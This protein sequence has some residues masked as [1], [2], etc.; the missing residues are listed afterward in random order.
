MYALSRFAGVREALS[1][2][3][4]FS[5]AQGV[6]MNEDANSKIKGN[7]LG[8]DPPLHTQLRH[9]LARPLMPSA[10]QEV[11]RLIERE[12]QARVRLLALDG[13]EERIVEPCAPE[14]H[15][16]A[17]H[18]RDLR[19]R[20]PHVPRAENRDAHLAEK[21]SRSHGGGVSACRGSRPL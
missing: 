18:G 8:S 1:N 2:W 10:M 17:A 12:A 6:A 19:H 16:V 14:A 21:T 11:T 20:A 7:T 3:E 4:V 15:V 9:V 13:V 5:N